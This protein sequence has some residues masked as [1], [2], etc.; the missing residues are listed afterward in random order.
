MRAT[1]RLVLGLAAAP[2]AARA[3][4]DRY[5]DRPVRIVVPFAPGGPTDVMARVLSAGLTAAL[6]QPVVV[7]NRGGGGGNIGAAH[8]ARSVPDGYT[9]LVASTGFVVNPSLF[10]NPGYDPVK[11]FAPVTELGAS[12]NVVIAGAQSRI[13]SIAGLVAAAK[14]RAGGL[15]I[16]NPGTG[17]T[18]HLTAELLRLRTG[19]EFVQITHNSAALAVQSVLGGITP[20][21]VAA[22]PPAQPHILSGAVRALAITSA[23]RWPDLPDVPTMQELG[24]PGFVSETFQALLAPAGTPPAIVDRLARESLATLAEPATRAKLRA[25]GFGVEARGPAALAERITREVPLWRDIIR[26][27]GIPLE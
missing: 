5:P 6:G 25:A 18:P 2:F 17:S 14:A 26:Q 4:G 13:A 23:T 20:V 24:Y 15:D 3:Q 7:E 27:A 12:P 9:L 19:V 22:L 1:R 11:D 8:V 21:G 16:A 10:R